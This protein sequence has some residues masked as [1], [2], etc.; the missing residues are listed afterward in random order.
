MMY[1]IRGLG[2]TFS[3][4]GTVPVQYTAPEPLRITRMLRYGARGDD[5][6]QWQRFIGVVPD[7]IFGGDT[8]AGTKTFQT[9]AGISVDGVVGP[10]TLKKAND[11]IAAQRA[12]E[13]VVRGENPDAPIAVEVPGGSDIVVGA[14]VDAAD[15]SETAPI[16]VSPPPEDS[17]EPITVGP[18]PAPGPSPEP[19]DPAPVDDPYARQLP[20]TGIPWWGYAIVGGGVLVLGYVVYTQMK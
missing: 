4:P 2:Q 13:A 8:L 6:K 12:G 5:V 15:P 18:G 10:D 19:T 20:S 3:I 16:V 7:G 9:F 17:T 14:P 11:L 1:G